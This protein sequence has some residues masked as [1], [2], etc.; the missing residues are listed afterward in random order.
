[1]KRWLKANGRRVTV[2]ADKWY[3]D[4]IQTILPYIQSAEPF[5]G[6]DADAALQATIALTLYFQDA[7]SQNGGW[8]QFTDLYHN[9]YHRTLPF[10]QTD[11]TYLSDEINR[12]D[13][14][15]VLWTR[16]ARPATLRSDDYTLFNPHDARLLQLS[17]TIYRIMDDWFEEAPI[18]E[19]PSGHWVSGTEGL[20]IP[21]TL[22]PPSTFAHAMSDNSRR[23]LEYSGGKPL[24]YFMDYTDL[25]QF[26]IDILQWENKPSA[27]LPDLADQHEFVLFANAKGLLIA[28]G[29]ASYFQDSNNPLFDM[30]RSITDSYRLFCEPGACPFDLLKFGMQ[31]GLL[32][33]AQFPFDN[34]KETLQNNADFIARYYLGEYYEGK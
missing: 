14:C 29:V 22:L 16:L 8:K 4:C 6:H 7:I 28:P 9:C 20:Q 1:M 15:F 18:N 21:S 23:C 19:T 26:F 13:I 10:Y 34:G 30:Q 25:K 17:Q 33:N 24:L 27:L 31:N 12:E 5:D 32:C 2:P 3:T 11:D